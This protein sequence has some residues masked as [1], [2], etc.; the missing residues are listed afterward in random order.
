MEIKLIKVQIVWAFRADQRIVNL[1]VPQGTTIR[2]VV[3]RSGLS[4]Y[5]PDANLS[6]CDFGIFGV[7]KTPDTK[8]AS[9]DRIEI[10]RPLVNDAKEIRRRRAQPAQ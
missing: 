8:V 7:R 5:F 2:E 4:Q 3:D 9:G 6:D 1:Q 10:Y